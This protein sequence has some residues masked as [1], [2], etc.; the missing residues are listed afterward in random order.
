MGFP[1]PGTR[2]RWVAVFGGSGTPAQRTARAQ[3]H[4]E[5]GE[6]LPAERTGHEPPAIRAGRQM[7][8]FVDDHA[9]FRVFGDLSRAEARRLGRYDSLV[10]QLAGGRIGEREF[11][12]RTSHWRPIR[13]E[14]FTSDPGPSWLP[15]TGAGT[16]NWRS[17]NIAP[18]GRHDGPVLLLRPPWTG[19]NAPFHRAR[20]AKGPLFRPRADRGTLPAVPFRCPR[21]AQAGGVGLA[22]SYCPR[23]P[24]RPH[25][26]PRRLVC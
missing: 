13:G 25:Q 7:S 10:S 23:P 11:E 12:R 19:R 1:R 24:G 16:R 8:A 26:C 21:H 18:G 5:I 9:E 15:S 14:R 3:L 4:Y 20:L 6:H 17:S 22:A 2:R